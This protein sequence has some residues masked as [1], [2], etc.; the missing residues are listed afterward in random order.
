[1][2]QSRIE[3]G[4]M[5]SPAV[6]AYRLCVSIGGAGSGQWDEGYLETISLMG[7]FASDRFTIGPGVSGQRNGR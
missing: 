1:M 7:R 4:S 5:D 3:I 6:T 2:P